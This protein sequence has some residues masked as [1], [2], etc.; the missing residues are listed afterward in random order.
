M[1]SAQ[2][3]HPISTKFGES[4]EIFIKVPNIKFHA[5]PSRWSRAD[6]CGETDGQTDDLVEANAT[7]K[8]KLMFDYTHA[9]L[10]TADSTKCIA[11]LLYRR[12]VPN[13]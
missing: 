12:E 11:V 8:I 3:F 9:E 13:C 4:R 10:G 5:N 6:I 7:K 2:Y 1:D